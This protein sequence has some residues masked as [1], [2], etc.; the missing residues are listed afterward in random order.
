[1]PLIS[2]IS[3]LQKYAV[4]SSNLTIESIQPSIFRA[5][6][7]YLKQFVGK[8]VY[9][10][11]LSI[12]EGNEPIVA[13]A[14]NVVAK[15]AL[16]IFITPGGVQ[17]DDSGIYQIKGGDKWRLSQ[18]EIEALKQSYLEE[19]MDALD[20]LL[21]DLEE[22][23]QEAA[24]ET[25]I[26][27]YTVYNHWFADQARNQYN[28]SLLK[29]RQVFESFVE[30]HHSSLTFH[31]LRSYVANVEKF[32]LMPLM[33]DY[34]TALMDMATPA[35]ND[36]ILLSLAQEAIAHLATAQALDR[37]FHGLNKGGISF[38]LNYAEPSH[39]LIGS[40]K[41]AAQNALERLRAKLQE[42]KPQGY[43]LLP[44][45]VSDGSILRKPGRR[46]ILA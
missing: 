4:V 18:Q 41:K 2:N 21:E 14:Q 43:T 34:Y 23:A 3:T 1:M 17:I 10:A 37:G 12:A 13:L 32:Q 46:I 7:K 30:L 35:G 28:N 33:G 6:K 5:E 24:E 45:D 39:E 36:A 38:D 8:K 44:S 25:E 31:S 19:A 26:A 9:E 40:Y 16:Y 15:F 42:L 20:L 22:N 11:L 27:E 29:T